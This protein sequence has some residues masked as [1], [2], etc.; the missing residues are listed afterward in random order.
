MMFARSGIWWRNAEYQV[1]H[2]FPHL[3]RVDGSPTRP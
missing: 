1:R 3:E 2:R